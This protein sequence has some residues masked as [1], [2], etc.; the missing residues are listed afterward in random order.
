MKCLFEIPFRWLYAL[1][2]GAAVVALFLMTTGCGESK[3]PTAPV[4]GLTL[5][6]A[7]VQ[8]NGQSVD[9]Q[10]LSRGHGQGSST[11]FEASLTQ[12]ARSAPGQMVRVKFD[13]PG[14]PGMMN[15]GGMFTLYDDG[16]HG[17]RM[18]GDG[19]YCYEDTV[20]DYG[21]HTADSPSGQ[22]HYDFYGM[23][24]GMHESNHM[25]VTVMIKP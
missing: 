11:R 5:A 18:P 23:H 7:S 19:I 10:T 12:D 25:V 8:V 16:T 3:S 4:S 13:R 15:Q 9:G 22:Y 2:I 14:G 24:Q 17:D 20:G 6:S 1:L 21:C